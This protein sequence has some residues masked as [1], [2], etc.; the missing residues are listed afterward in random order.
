MSI[1]RLPPRGASERQR[2]FAINQLVQQANAT[3]A[4]TLLAANNLSDLASAATARIN[5]G[6]REVLTANRTYYVRTD[7]SD[8]NTGLVDSAGGAFRNIAAAKA[9]YEALDFNNKT[10]TIQVDGGTYTAGLSVR[11][12]VGGGAL[13][14]DGGGGTLSTSAGGILVGGVLGGAFT[15]QNV[16]I[17]TSGSGR[18]V[19]IDGVGQITQGVGVVHGTCG[20]IF[21][22]GVNVPG[23][24]LICVSPYTISGGCAHHL[25]LGS[26]GARMAFTSA[27][28]CTVTG[29]PAFSTAF[30][31]AVALGYISHTGSFSGG[32]TGK[33]YISSLN[34]VINTGTGANHF[35]GNV[36]GT[37]TTG[38]Y[39]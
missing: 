27:A 10:V 8:A 24:Y 32:A 33:R 23:A 2:D 11:S 16:T 12:W 31:E 38:T 30:V 1:D 25:Y 37:A 13:I 36:A 15:Y 35:P 5:L 20:G 19:S 29:T 7:G 26:A 28:V 4:G 22:I 3:P 14:F 17:T 6:V 39:I 34:S 9:A 18:N 21:Q